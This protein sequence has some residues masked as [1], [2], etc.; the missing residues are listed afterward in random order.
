MYVGFL[1][2]SDRSI[3]RVSGYLKVSCRLQL[4]FKCGT[5][6]D[7]AR[8]KLRFDPGFAA[9]R[10]RGKFGSEVAGRIDYGTVGAYGSFLAGPRFCD[11]ATNDYYCL[12]RND[13]PTSNI[14]D[15]DILENQGGRGINR[16][17]L[18][19]RQETKKKAKT[20]ITVRTTDSISNLGN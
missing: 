12:I 5:P 15:C 4:V 8:T 18:A 17:C 6:Q 11:S 9:V 20:R 13:P 7:M 10:L 19:R 16:Q 2:E 14:H 3:C 1:A